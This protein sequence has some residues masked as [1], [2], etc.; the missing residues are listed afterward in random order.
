MRRPALVFGGLAAL[1]TAFFTSRVTA[2]D[3][4][5]TQAYAPIVAPAYVVPTTVYYPPAPA[6]VE[7][8][9]M[10]PAA[11]APVTTYSPV[12]V[13]PRRWI[14]YSPVVWPRRRQWSRIR[15]SCLRC[16]LP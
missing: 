1:S 15:P 12:V 4:V 11:V 16:P 9:I 14:T 13:T 7:A 3:L 2:N 6:M 10:A 8:P 5:V